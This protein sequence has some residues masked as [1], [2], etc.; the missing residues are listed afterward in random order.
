MNIL[1]SLAVRM[2]LLLLAG[3]LL[4][5][6]SIAGYVGYK[7]LAEAEE[8]AESMYRTNTEALALIGD[9]YAK[10][11]RLRVE[12]LR[13]D[14]NATAPE[15]LQEIFD[16][17]VREVE[18]F[19]KTY[20]ET[21]SDD[22]D[23]VQHDEFKKLVSSYVVDAG[24]MVEGFV[25]KNISEEERIRLRTI[26]GDTGSDIRKITEKMMSENAKKAEENFQSI[27]SA[28]ER[29]F[30]ALFVTVLVAFIIGVLLSLAIIKSITSPLA[31]IQNTLFSFFAYVNNETDSAQ[32]MS[33]NTRD[34]FGTMAQ[35]INENIAKI[36]AGLRKDRAL[37]KEIAGIVRKA[38]DG[39]LGFLAE[40][41]ANNPQ[42]EELKGLL[43][44]M[45]SRFKESISGVVA[46]LNV[47]SNNDFTP[48]IDPGEI[49]GDGRALID[50]VNHM[51]DEVAKM[52]RDSLH[53]GQEME[54]KARVL[55][56]SMQTLS[57]GANE[58]A[59]SLEQ[60]AAA[61]EEMS[62]S[63]HS[64]SERSN[65]VIRQS[66]DIKSV[67]SIIRDIADQT[68]LLALNAAIEAARAG[69][70]GRGF[71][72]VAD[73][74]RKLAERT[75]KSLGEIEANTNILVQSI[76]E[77]SESIKEQAQG[78]GQINEAIAQLDTVTQQNAGV[79]DK[80]DGIATEVSSMAE[81][82]VEEAKKKKF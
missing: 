60:S 65:E 69:E 2:K 18:E 26:L 66:E 6:I 70:H 72:V 12:I 42:L 53:T 36:E 19:D 59:A 30:K 58:Q 3:V 37:I 29:D 31:M 34:E 43:N 67:I 71:A 16:G 64:V 56:E 41:S 5:G 38:D 4:V 14:L 35:A 21:Y 10:L 15:K 22:S 46:T 9:F 77:M 17:F 68:N 80:T 33:L 73:E 63:M 11:A 39:Y 81:G 13:I 1:G 45:L 28:N 27:I 62:S 49:Q 44:T 79:A 52:L 78:I 7:G 32:K 55:K 25:K 8:S 54:E 57:Q 75:Q 23:R 82:I 24:K 48:R 40:S 20:P 76:N 74:V 47:Y 50:G 61:I 51:G